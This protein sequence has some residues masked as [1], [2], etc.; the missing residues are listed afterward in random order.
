MT[1]QKVESLAKKTK[2]SLLAGNGQPNQQNPPSL[3]ALRI[4]LSSTT[5]S[6]IARLADVLGE[7]GDI[8][9]EGA[10]AISQQISILEQE[11]ERRRSVVQGV[12]SSVRHPR[13]RR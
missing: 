5:I 6:D 8:W 2:A 10:A 11:L 9:P 1:I 4:A 7:L 13:R 3:L 12:G